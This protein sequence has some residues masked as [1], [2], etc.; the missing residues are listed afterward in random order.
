ML[1]RYF[2]SVS[3]DKDPEI[4]VKAYISSDHVTRYDQTLES[5]L[6]ERVATRR[7][8]LTQELQPTRNKEP[9]LSKAIK[10][11]TATPDDEGHLQLITGGVGVG[12]SLFTRRYKELLQPARQVDETHWAFIDFN[13]APPSLDSAENWLCERFVH[14]FQQ[15]NPSFDPYSTKNLPR[16]FSQDLRRMKGVYAELRKV[17]AAEA[18]R[19]KANDLRDW[20]D[21]PDRLAFGICRHFS[22]DR[23]RV[24]VVV[25][26]NV[27]RLDLK[28][29][30]Q[31][32]QLALW[33]KEGSRAF[34]ILQMRDETYERF[35]SQPPLDTYRTG[36]AFHIS[37]PRFLDVVKRRLELSLEYLAEATEERR[38][39]VLDGG[40]RIVYPSSRL[41]E[42]L[43]EIYL[44]LF[45]RK[46]K[47]SRVLQ[48]L[49]G[50]D[51][52]RAL[53]MFVS[54]LVSGHLHE[55]EITSSAVGA[56]SFAIREYTVLKILM[57]TEYRFFSN[58][59]GFVSNLFYLDEEWEQP[60]NFLITDLLF[61]LYQ[62]RKKTGSIGLEGY[63][64]VSHIAD[65]LQL[66]G[67][68]ANDVMSACSWLVKRYLIES[69]AMNYSEVGIADSVKV[70]AS[71]FIHLRILSNRLKYIYGLLS[72]TPISDDRIAEEIGEHIYR[73]NQR[74]HIAGYHM[75]RCVQSFLRYLRNEH[76][77]LSESYP[78][79]GR[80]HN[81]ASYVISQ[82]QGAIDYF[83][84]PGRTGYTQPNLLD[85]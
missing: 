25:M 19:A 65:V 39:Y 26:D 55:E 17:S 62:N 31:A 50:R 14:S 15:E 20:Q 3:Q 21:D 82:V 6:R 23:R 35:K 47:V 56:G 40:A 10:G 59:S 34:V 49:A 63:F 72:V 29:Q 67:Y 75:I 70:T 53:E 66:R 64:S 45:E 52:R 9:T 13:T 51:V 58:N 73:E 28:S 54:I 5:L 81:G 7:G 12:K 37:P 48:G 18:N 22:G 2:T 57:R 61:W 36:V 77:L 44:E 80:K 24:V 68:V 32:F 46:N 16:I 30:L 8:S 11:F 38:E 78:E 33:F 76:K 41:G 60:N 27:D 83:R 42:F 84:N 71:G 79:F 74:G 4:Y 85:E 69:D 43:R 1:R